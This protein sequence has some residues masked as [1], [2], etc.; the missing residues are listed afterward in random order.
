M[1]KDEPSLAPKP[2]GFYIKQELDTRGWGQ[3]DLA[4]ILDCH[5]QAVNLI[6]S[7]KRG[8]SPDMAKA[9]GAAFDV[10]AEFFLNLQKT[11]DLVLARDPDPGISMRARLQSSYP[12]REMIRRGWLADA[13][14][15]NLELQMARFFEVSSVEDIPHLPHAGKKP[16]Y[17]EIPPPQ[18]AWLFRVRQI[19]RSITVAAYSSKKLKASL[20]DLRQ[21]L[22]DPEDIRHVAGIVAESGVRFVVVEPLPQGKIDGVCFWLDDD[23][24]VIGMS[25]RYDRID[26]FWFVLRHEIEHVLRE[27]G[28]NDEI[29]V[30]DE[31]DGNRA[32]VDGPGLPE[33][34]LIANRAAAEFCIPQDEMVE[35]ISR[36]IPYISERD[37]LSF[38][39]RL[40]VHP[41][42]VV[43]QIHSRTGRYDFLRRYLV[44]IRQ[45]LL[46][47]ATADGW[48]HV[49]PT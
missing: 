43:G 11:Y 28:Q 3:R 49:F 40:E 15:A 42:L 14:A 22:T 47:E 34:E 27:H 12:V 46:Q 39:K 48:G 2:P 16:R 32:A 7:G 8:I 5:E 45:F 18:L 31:L 13:D 17:D 21:L 25:L 19:A 6:V 24:P 10:S 4:Y 26:N 36:R 44:K 9:L 1:P 30:V 29:G 35:F 23:S 38:A 33:Q 20:S 37:V 41:G